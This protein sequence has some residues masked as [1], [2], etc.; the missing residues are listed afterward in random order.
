MKGLGT[1]PLM[2]R[3]SM[4]DVWLGTYNTVYNTIQCIEKERKRLD[5][6][7]SGMMKQ[8]V[9]IVLTKENIYTNETKE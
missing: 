9:I 5:K 4:N 2:T 8:T 3:I 6:K 1:K 7:L